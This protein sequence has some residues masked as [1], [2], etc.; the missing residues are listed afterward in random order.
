MCGICGIGE[1]RSKLGIDESI[2]Q[3]ML[4][5]L[6]HRGPDDKGTFVSQSIVL[7]PSRLAIIDLT[8]G[9]M[10]ICNEDKTIWIVFNGEIY[11]FRALREYLLKK[12]HQF[13]TYSDT[14]VIVHLYEE[15]GVECV[16]H[17]N[18]IFAF[19][20][21]DSRQ[22]KLYVA[23]DRMGIKPLY[24][25]EVDGQLIFA[26][27]MKALLAH[28]KVKRD[29]DPISLNEYLSFEYVPSPRTI[30]TNVSRLPS[31]SWLTYSEVGLQ[32]IRYYQLS[33]ARSEMQ[34]PVDWRDYTALL[35]AKLRESIKQELVSDVPVG[36][37]LS[38]GIDSS[39]VAS[40]MAEL[41]P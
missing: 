4:A 15:F 16:Q 14:E 6:H 8:T 41:S 9:R 36:V 31:G 34:P 39:V 29:I 13:S 22:Q 38:G 12:G 11:N 26:S 7:G 5:C 33:L 37:L 24:Y 19:A 32:V 25:T 40:Y 17:L 20:I 18:G 28:P 10:P 21:W 30:I 35:D 2:V 23:R 27:E 1:F 3:K